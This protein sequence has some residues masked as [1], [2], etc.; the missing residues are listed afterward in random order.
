MSNLII[1]G[2]AKHTKDCNDWCPLQDGTRTGD[3]KYCNLSL[4]CKQVGMRSDWYKFRD[5]NGNEA[6]DYFCTGMYID[7]EKEPT[8][9]DEEVK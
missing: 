1:P 7:P 9:V 5:E 8:N 4:V 2:E 3:P 6:F